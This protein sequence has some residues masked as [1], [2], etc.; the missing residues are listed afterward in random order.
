MEMAGLSAH[1]S[2]R[3]HKAVAETEA[4]T[5][6]RFALVVV[7]ASDRY[8]FFPLV[9]GT[10]L[11]LVAGAALAVIWPEIGLRVGLALQAAI[12]VIASLLLDWRPLRLL[13]V[14]S[15]IK[16][17]YARNMAHREFAAR[18]LASRE[19]ESGMVFFVSLGERYVE[20][21]ADRALHERVGE[22]A[23]QRIVTKFAAA[24]KTGQLADGFLAGIEASARILET[25][26]P[27]SG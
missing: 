2:E 9:Y 26:V 23:W 27:T 12:L 5:R 14:P 21:I 7:P 17:M 3:V 24:A 1:D 19:H 15:H 8:M 10:L 20:I 13:L 18:V 25:H 22:E 16:Q 6:A 4:R 11:A